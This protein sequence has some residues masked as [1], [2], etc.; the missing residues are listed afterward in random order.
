MPAIPA[1]STDLHRVFVTLRGILEPYV[2]RMRVFED[3]DHS[4]YLNAPVVM[5]N[6]QPLFFAST[7]IL[8]RY[9][10]FHFQPLVLYPDLMDEHRSLA[11]RMEGTSSFSFSRLSLDDANALRRIVHEGYERFVTGYDLPS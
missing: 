6:G 3:N 1:T 10:S 4:L 11:D 7:A 5:P 9:V 2:A 8:P